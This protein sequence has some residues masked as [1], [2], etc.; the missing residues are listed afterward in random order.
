MEKTYQVSESFIKEAYNAACQD[1]K[2]KLKT[3]F[4]DVFKKNVLE[5]GKWYKANPN[6][7]IFY[8]TD[9]MIHAGTD[10]DCKAFGV[11][12]DG[13]WVNDKWG[14]ASYNNDNNWNREATPKEVKDMLIKE[15]K[16][17][18]LVQDI[19]IDSIWCTGKSG[20]KTAGEYRFNSHNN[21]L[22]LDSKRT[23]FTL[24]KDGIWAK[25]WEN[26]PTDVPTAE[27]IKRVLN[28]LKIK[29]DI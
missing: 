3:Q 2:D 25:P 27:E 4:P 6:Q 26:V 1:W 8:V 12:F 20:Q 22:T 5:K 29:Y 21:A 16:K 14:F 7:S 17:R 15:A 24:F 28:H 19:Y 18:G 13:N 10:G 9:I 23:E 11:D